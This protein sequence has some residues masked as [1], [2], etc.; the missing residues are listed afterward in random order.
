MLQLTY[1][2]KCWYLK[3]LNLYSAPWFVCQCLS[4]CLLLCVYIHKQALWL[5]VGQ[6]VSVA[7]GTGTDTECTAELYSDIF[8]KEKTNKKTLHAWT[9]KPEVRDKRSGDRTCWNLTH[10]KTTTNK[11]AT[12]W[13]SEWE[14][15]VTV[16][17][18]NT[19]WDY[20]ASPNSESK[21]HHPEHGARQWGKNDVPY[22][23][24]RPIQSAVGHQ[25]RE[26]YNG[27]R[28]Q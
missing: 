15:R 4:I 16:T 25:W 1:V 8:V 17:C 9:S 18:V 14:F 11:Q 3:R 23:K 20:Q 10:C 28:Q 24:Q 19:C 6:D 12:M 7:F 22:T 27:H 13:V 5:P 2:R 21:R 26:I